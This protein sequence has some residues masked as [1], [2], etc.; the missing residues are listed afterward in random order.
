VH[1]SLPRTEREAY[2]KGEGVLCAKGLK[3]Q[4]CDD[5]V[6]TLVKVEFPWVPLDLKGENVLSVNNAYHD[7]LVDYMVIMK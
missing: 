6:L 5:D 3:A 7:L 2:L 1:W 4:P